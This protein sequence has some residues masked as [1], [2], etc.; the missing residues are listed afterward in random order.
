MDEKSYPGIIMIA[1]VI[2]NQLVLCIYPELSTIGFF[3]IISLFVY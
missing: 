1:D 2:I 3:L